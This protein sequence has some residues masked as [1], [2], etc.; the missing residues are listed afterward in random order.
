MRKTFL[1]AGILLTMVILGP[2][3]KVATLPELV[4]PTAILADEG[5]IYIV[6]GAAVFI[7]SAKTFKLVKSFGQKGE[8]P[9]EF[10]VQNNIGLQLSPLHENL[11]ITTSNKFFFF[12]KEGKQEKVVPRPPAIGSLTRFGPGYLGRK[13]FNEEG[14]LAETVVLYDGNFKKI[15]EVYR[16]DR[17]KAGD[18]RIYLFDLERR[19]VFRT[20]REH[21][22]ILD[23]NPFSIA[24]YGKN[25]GL[26]RTLEPDYPRVTIT[27]NDK[28]LLY[29]YYKLL[30]KDFQV[31]KRRLVIPARY[32]AIY[33]LDEYNGKLRVLTWK[34]SGKKRELLLL[35]L[36][37]NILSRSFIPHKDPL[38]GDGNS[39][40][41]FYKDRLYQLYDNPETETWDLHMI[42][43]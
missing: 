10:K 3:Q 19:M 1:V 37:G 27:A 21:M 26:L 22:Y 5:Q 34:V 28:K 6:C 33:D 18:N 7:Y 39:P 30:V 8:G 13:N 31:I 32:P 43:L 17:L 20:G 11:M 14:K 16:R 35:D 12:S 9:G 41:C 25:G 2:A 36:K 24:V 4:K 40:Y 38:R 42:Q 23:K 29:D 15:K